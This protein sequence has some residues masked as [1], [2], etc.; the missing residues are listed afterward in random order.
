M[1]KIDKIS[2]GYNDRPPLF[3]KFLMN[4]S[5]GDVCAV[6][7]PSG[8][9]KSTFLYLLAGLCL[10]LS[11]KIIVNNE[12]IERP[13]PKTGLVLQDH[14][15]LPW[16]TVWKNAMLG[17]TIREFY[18]PDER[19]APRDGFINKDEAAERV[20]HWLD[21][22]S[23]LHLKDQYPLKLSRGQ[24]QRTAIARTMALEPDLLLLDEPF[25]ALDVPTRESLQKLVLG[26]N[27]EHELTIVLVTH[28][29]DEAVLMGGTI[30]VLDDS[31]NFSPR[32]MENPCQ[33]DFGI[34]K[35][36]P[37]AFTREKLRQALGAGME[38]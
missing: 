34:E 9:G 35:K 31:T 8:C 10:P 1:I 33:G 5:H 18:G 32:L 30:L 23:I 29:I 26:L 14:G 19:H 17:L 16:A 6:I 22:L 3:D 2:F 4:I 24:R 37:F 13:R 36:T 38:S 21:R 28:D 20:S 11:G 27:K 25:S 7:G 12:I 15:L